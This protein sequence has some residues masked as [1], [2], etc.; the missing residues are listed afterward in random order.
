MLFTTIGGM[1]QNDPN[2]SW[3]PVAASCAT[4]LELAQT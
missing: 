1:L 2:H 4:S 3:A